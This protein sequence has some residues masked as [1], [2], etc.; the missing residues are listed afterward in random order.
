MEAIRDRADIV[1]IIG[2]YVTLRRAGSNMVG[3]CPFH[4]EKTPSF[5]VFP[6]SQNF[7]C[8]GCEAGGDVITFIM[9]SENLDYPDAVEFLA[10][11][12]GVEIP[13]NGDMPNKGMSRRRVYEM[14]LEAARFFRACLFDENIGRAG[15]HYLAEQ[16]KLPLPIIKHFGLG[17]APA[18]FGALISVLKKKGYTDAE[19]KEAF[20]CGISQKTGR[21]YDY[22]RNRVI[23][24]IIDT[25]GNVVA[26]GGRV[27]DDSKPKY[28]NTSDT[29]GFKKGRTLFALN[30]AKNHCSDELILCE[31]YMDV[32]ALH[33]AG[34]ENAVATLGTALTPDQARIISKYTQRVVL[35]YD[36]DEAGQRATARALQIFADVGVE[37][38]VLQMHGAKDPDEYIKKFG[39]DKFAGLLKQSRSGFDFKLSG[40]L[41]RHDVTLPEEKIRA[42]NELCDI[43]SR[44]Y[45]TA[46]REIYIDEVARR[47]SLSKESLTMDVERMRRRHY[48]E[49]KQAEMKQAQ[50][51]AM[52]VGDRINPEAA[53]SVQ[54]AAAENAI[55]GLLLMYEEHR[56]AV[57][58]GTVELS[59]ADF[60]TDFSRRAFV[61]IM[62]L[63]SSDGGFMFSLLGESFSAD[64]M[65]RLTRLE[66]ARR[67]LTENSTAVLRTSIEA[68]RTEKNRITA[69]SAD[70]IS[71]IEQLLA[72]KRKK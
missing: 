41:S 65:G 15:M 37:V 32:V 10:K 60:F 48:K 36:S 7:F 58:R 12:V 11:R 39:R 42:A 19:M 70:P 49:K 30:Y 51:T 27:L 43:I 53:S 8:F 13:Q 63:Q 4:S 6:N 71:G 33:A 46:E 56:L 21:P 59:E 24:P 35:C 45:S 17:Y 57:Q 26:F 72:A 25:T 61:E 38:R 9:R 16:R 55:I 44:V 3:V 23:F 62:K 64:E 68:L 50:V 5:T 28:L 14:N 2:S 29:P 47:L 66:Q 69:K 31:G 34:F 18:D 40:V 52:S 20:L 67:A 22:F 1:D 54:A